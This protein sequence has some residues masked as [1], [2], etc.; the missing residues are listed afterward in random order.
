MDV[1]GFLLLRRGPIPLRATGTPPPS[2]WAQ[3]CP[4][5]VGLTALS[6]REPREDIHQGRSREKSSNEDGR[7][8]EKVRP[9]RH[10]GENRARGEKPGGET[11]VS[12]EKICGNRLDEPPAGHERKSARAAA[13]GTRK[14]GIRQ[15]RTG[16]KESSR[17]GSLRTRARR[18]SRERS[19]RKR[20]ARTSG[21]GSRVTAHRITRGSRLRSASLR[22]CDSTR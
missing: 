18:Y 3:G 19:R 2:R 22:P 9:S 16:G 5:H 12:S 21:R 17:A 8:R 6:T 14:T 13:A 11:H 1:Q 4:R 10:E 15:R 20:S 7:S